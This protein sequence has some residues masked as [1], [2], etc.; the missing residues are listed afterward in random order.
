MFNPRFPE[1]SNQE[2]I[3]LCIDLIDY[4]QDL[5]HFDFSV[6]LSKDGMYGARDPK[7][8]TWNGMLHELQYFVS[9]Y[10]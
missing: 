3:G 10:I 9:A 5:L 7:T 4:L 6:H 8:D 2:L 1:E